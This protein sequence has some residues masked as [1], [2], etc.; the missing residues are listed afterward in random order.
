MEYVVSI[1][2][3][4]ATKLLICLSTSHMSSNVMLSSEYPSFRY[5]RRNEFTSAS[6]YRALIAVLTHVLFALF[7]RC[8]YCTGSSN[9][10]ADQ[11]CIDIK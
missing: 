1:V 9:D 8:M 6:L 10:T 4:S 2:N 5:L 3:K 7:C 11:W